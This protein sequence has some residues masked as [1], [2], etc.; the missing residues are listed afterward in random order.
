M[1]LATADGVTHRLTWADRNAGWRLRCSCGWI[2][3]KLRWTETNAVRQGNSHALAARHGKPA[4]KGKPESK[5]KDEA[6]AIAEAIADGKAKGEAAVREMR[7]GPNGHE[8]IGLRAVG[9]DPW[10][11][12]PLRRDRDQDAH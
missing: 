3:P 11:G 12:K 2:D 1:V 7:R 10:T 4:A 5:S 8:P 9:I 6:K